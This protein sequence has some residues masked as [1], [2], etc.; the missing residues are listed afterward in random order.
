MKRMFSRSA[1]LLLR[2]FSWKY[3]YFNDMSALLFPFRMVM[4]LSLCLFAC[5]PSSRPADSR[6][7]GGGSAATQGI[8]GTLSALGGVM[9]PPPDCG[10]R[11]TP[12]EKDS[13]LQA[14]E[15][16]PIYP[17]QGTV[18]IRNSATRDSIL[19]ES[20]SLGA[21]RAELPPGSYQVCV[22]GSSMPEGPVCSD[23]LEVKKGV[24]TAY[25]LVHPMP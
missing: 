5:S 7:A 3:G 9:P 17:L 2:I 15:R 1:C 23:T 6:T 21:Y 16:A 11:L 19:L 12:A 25:E 22:K 14:G 8:S 18:I 20:D 10:E 13:C 4:C 24:F